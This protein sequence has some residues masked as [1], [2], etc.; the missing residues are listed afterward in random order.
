MIIRCNTSIWDDHY[1]MEDI[2]QNSAEIMYLQSR[3]SMWLLPKRSLSSKNILRL[4][5]NA[6][7]NTSPFPWV[8]ASKAAHL[9]PE[10]SAII[11]NFFDPINMFHYFISEPFLSSFFP[12]CG[13]FTKIKVFEN[14][15]LF[16][17]VSAIF[18]YF[19]QD[20]LELITISFFFRICR[21]R[22][23]SSTVFGRNC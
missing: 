4:C 15:H 6:W 13:F 14:R 8:L 3:I 16:I 2:R 1:R 23:W 5:R 12:E 9:N 11:P 17:R 21:R 20:H 18:W 7:C 22:T 19:C 10:I